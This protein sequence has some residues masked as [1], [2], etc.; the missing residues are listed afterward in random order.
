MDGKLP[1]KKITCFRYLPDKL[2]RVEQIENFHDK[3]EESDLKKIEA[4]FEEKPKMT[5]EDLRQ[6]LFDV[7]GFDPTEESFSILFM[8]INSTRYLK[9]PITR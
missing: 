9:Y 4:A 5:Q 1:Q 6:I 8:K 7:I 3:F 2:L